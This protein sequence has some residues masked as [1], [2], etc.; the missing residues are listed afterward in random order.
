MVKM[1]KH[2]EV[3]HCDMSSSLEQKVA[4]QQ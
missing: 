2:E 3:A 4:W 1:L